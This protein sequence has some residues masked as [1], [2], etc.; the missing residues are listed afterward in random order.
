M[1]SPS[2]HIRRQ[3]PL[4]F[5]LFVAALL[6]ALLALGASYTLRTLNL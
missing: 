3:L 6:A 5:R 1:Y 2:S 4:S